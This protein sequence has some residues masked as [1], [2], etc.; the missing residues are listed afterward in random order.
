MIPAH[1]DNVRL[2]IDINSMA[3]KYGMVLKN[4]EIGKG[5]SGNKDP[6]LSTITGDGPEYLDMR[7]L[8]SGSYDAMKLFVTDLSRSLRIVDITDLTFSARDLDLY[9]FSISLRTYWLQDK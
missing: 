5:S 3:D 6:S 8:V 2:V 4:I 1:V 9:D 7:F